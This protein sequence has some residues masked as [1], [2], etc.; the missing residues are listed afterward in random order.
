MKKTLLLLFMFISTQLAFGQYWEQIAAFPGT[1]RHSSASFSLNGK[2]YI[3]G[4][5]GDNNQ[6]LNDVWQY[7]PAANSFTQKNNLPIAVYGA[8]CVVINNTAYLINGW[9]TTNQITND[10]LYRYDEQN[11]TWISVSLYPGSPAYTCASFVLNDK[12]YVGIGYAPYTNELWE[13]DPATD[14]W[15]QKANFP[16]SYR[17]NCTAFVI[18]NIAYVGLGADG[19]DAFNDIYSY[20]PQSDSWIFVTNLPG[21]Q[22]YAANCFVIDDKA[23]ISCGSDLTNFLDD[24]WEFDP[25]NMTWTQVTNYGGAATHACNY[26]TIN[27]VGYAGL[28]RSAVFQSDMW[29]FM[30]GGLNEIRG[31]AFR[32]NDSNGT[33]DSTDTPEPQLLVQLSP[34]GNVYSTNSAGLFKLPADTQITYTLNV[35]NVPN[36]YTLS[37]TNNPITFTS[38]GNI[39][40]STQFILTPNSA[41]SDA[42]IYLSS[43]TPIRAGF[44]GFYSITCKNEGTTKLDS[45]HVTLEMQYGLQYLNTIPASTPTFT[46]VNNDTVSWTY[47]NIQPGET[48]SYLVKYGFINFTG[49]LGDS[50]FAHASVYTGV[51]ESDT[52]NNYSTYVDTLVGSFDPN[53]IS[54]SSEILTPSEV[55]S[56]KW[57]TYKIRFQNTGTYQANFVRVFDSIPAG[58]DLSSFELLAYSHQPCTFTV[59]GN[60]VVKFDFPGIVLPDSTSNEPESHGFIEFRIKPKT[61]LAIGDMITNRADI[62]FDFNPAVI[63]NDAVTTVVDNTSIAEIHAD[64]NELLVFPNPADDMIRVRIPSGQNINGDSKICIFD[65]TGKEAMTIVRPTSE[66]ISIKSLASGLYRIQLIQTDGKIMTGSFVRK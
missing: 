10:S 43:I 12:L 5:Y 42:S 6:V 52:T 13:Y 21:T 19:L 64:K 66:S 17:Q 11:D 49:S 14:I 2:G 54:V 7:D 50:V 36:N 25:F 31:I 45:I 61:T 59:D 32:D 27:G 29:K 30:P 44:D 34:G 26:F 16:G 3:V 38:L 33:Q 56:A 51:T 65:I 1:L 15:A 58:L 28:G 60:N 39:D 8:S 18:N 24:C 63:T 23:Y 40:S 55:A 41:V 62:Y 22:R 48:K 57:L 20:D 9:Q 4:G 37:G 35:L 47:Y 53:D 46:S